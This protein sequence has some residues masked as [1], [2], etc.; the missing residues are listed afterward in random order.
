M[1]HPVVAVYDDKRSSELSVDI[2]KN[3]IMLTD[4]RVLLAGVDKLIKEQTNII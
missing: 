2:T 1:S 4:G 3:G